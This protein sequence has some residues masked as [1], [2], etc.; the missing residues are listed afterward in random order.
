MDG[1]EI[2]E[3]YIPCQCIHIPVVNRET[4]SR[5]I[6]YRKIDQLPVSFCCIPCNSQIPSIQDNILIYIDNII[7]ND[8]DNYN[9][10]ND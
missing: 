1:H 2:K 6:R 5:Q 7:K 9:N 10:D 3:I 8:N 4:N